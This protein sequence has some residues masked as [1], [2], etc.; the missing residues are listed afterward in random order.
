MKSKI[1]KV[2]CLERNL[3]S[4]KGG[5]VELASHG[6]INFEMCISISSVKKQ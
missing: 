5:D 6:G 3:G 2:S 4:A 1:G